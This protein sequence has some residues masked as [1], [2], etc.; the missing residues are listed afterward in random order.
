MNSSSIAKTLWWLAAAAWLVFIFWLA[1]Q[2]D[3]RSDWDFLDMLPFGDKLYHA[4]SYGVLTALLYMASGN[5]LLALSLGSG[6]GAVDE[7]VQLALPYRAADVAD[8]L[9]DVTGAVL[10]VGL[11]VYLTRRGTPGPKSV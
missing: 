9:A 3:L 5:A 7:L 10:A 11:A 8:W 4:G 1:N 6:A 2:P